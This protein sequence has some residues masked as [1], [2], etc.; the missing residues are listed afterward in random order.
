MKREMDLVR[1]IL[2]KVEE[3][4]HLRLFPSSGKPPC[5]NRPA[6]YNLLKSV[7]RTFP[8]GAI[9]CDSRSSC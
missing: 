7:V 9:E 5:S 2:L 6:P 3:L 8:F 1:E 4:N